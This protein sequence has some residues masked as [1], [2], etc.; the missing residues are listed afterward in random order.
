MNSRTTQRNGLM[1]RVRSVTVSFSDTIQLP[2][3]KVEWAP[4]GVSLITKWPF[5]EG[6][7]VEFAFDHGGTRHCC[8][9]VVVACRAL[10]RPSGHYST[11]L[12]FV[13]VPC[14]ELRHAACDC[15]LAHP[16]HRPCG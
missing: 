4:N 9:G 10:D 7:E 2:R 14:N 6:T 12:Y 8:I 15:Q 13:E 11:I 16:R 5:A 3:K 1:R